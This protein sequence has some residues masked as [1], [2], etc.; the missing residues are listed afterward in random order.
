MGWRDNHKQ[1]WPW[2]LAKLAFAVAAVALFPLVIVPWHEEQR[3]L[4]SQVYDAQQIAEREAMLTPFREV[5]AGGNR[6]AILDYCST[7]IAAEFPYGHRLQAL[8]WADD[9]VDAYVYVSAARY[10][11]RRV[12]CSV[13]GIHW[14]RIDHPL[15]ALIPV[16]EPPDPADG[17][18][19]LWS[20][21][22]RLVALAPAELRSVE[23]LMRPD[24]GH[25]VQRRVTRTGTGWNI[26]V[27]PVEAPKL[28]LLSTSPTLLAMQAEGGG[29]ANPLPAPAQ[30]YPQRR[31]SSATSEAFEFLA[32][33]LPDDAEGRIVGL[34]FNDDEIKVA[35][36]GPVAGLDAP[37]GDIE[38]DAWGAAT[39]WLYPRD[40]PPGF[41]CPVGRPLE[42]VRQM[43]LGRC[44]ELPGC[45][46]RTHFSIADYSCSSAG[47]GRWQLHIQSAN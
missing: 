25:V 14:S 5:F 2:V 18:E 33:E 36:A 38:F 39:T 3:R 15:A 12:T 9:R 44:A 34:R 26:E 22:G 45:K 42:Q 20:R 35:V 21:M 30:T 4:E 47:D 1:S 46:A 28:P 16:E 37:Y 11:L 10:G 6:S 31:W 7:A 32:R 17:P 40:E 8:A 27:E 13:E 41:G 24:D 19:N 23:L 43:F 29:E